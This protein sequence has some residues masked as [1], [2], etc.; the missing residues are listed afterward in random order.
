MATPSRFMPIAARDLVL[1]RADGYQM[2]VYVAVGAP[3]S[4]AKAD[5]MKQYAGCLVLTCDEPDLATEIYG[6]DEMEA[7]IAALEFIESFLRRLVV[8]SGGQLRGSDGHPFDPAGSTLL[9][10]SRQLQSRM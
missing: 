6:A 8:E 1:V 2:P 7:L 10:E 4:P 9:K 5:E 3:Y